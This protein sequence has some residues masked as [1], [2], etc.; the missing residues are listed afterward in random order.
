M[1][2][3]QQQQQSQQPQQ[4]APPQQPQ[5][6]QAA[7]STQQ[8]SQ[9][10]QQQHPV[11]PATP[12]PTPPTQH[13]L[14]P[15]QH[16]HQQHQQQQNSAVSSLASSIAMNTMAIT[17]PNNIGIAQQG[18]VASI[19]SPLPQVQV[20]HQAMHSPSYLPQ[21]SYNQQQ[22]MLQNA[23]M[24]AAMQ[25]S[26][27][28]IN[29]Q[30]LN[31][32]NMAV[33]MQGRPNS[34]MTA[35]QG[36]L[37]HS[38]TQVQQ[39]NGR[40]RL[41]LDSWKFYSDSRAS[42]P[43][44][45]FCFLDHFQ[46]GTP[47]I[48]SPP[49]SQAY[50]V[51]ATNA[52]S[53]TGAIMGNGNKM[54]SQAV[55]QQHMQQAQQVA[56]ATAMVGK[57]V[58]SNQ[59]NPPPLLIGQLGV[60]PG[61]L[62][63]N[64][65]FGP[66]SKQ[67]QSLSMAGQAQPQLISTQAPVRFSQAQLV[68][69]TGQIITSQPMLTN[70]IMQAMAANLQQGI[71]IAHQPI[72]SAPNQSP[73]I[74]TG[75][76]IYLRP[77]SAMQQ[78]GIMGVQAAAINPNMRGNA[79]QSL[80][81]RPSSAAIP[82]QK[83]TTAAQTGKVILPSTSKSATA[84]IQPSIN[85]NASGTKANI[86]SLKSPKALGRPKGTGKATSA[87][88]MSGSNG[89]PATVQAKTSAQISKPSTP[90]SQVAQSLTTH[91]SKSQSDSELEVG[92]KIAGGNVTVPLAV[93]PAKEKREE[94]EDSKE[95][96]SKIGA[97]S[98]LEKPR[99]I[100]TFELKCGQDSPM[101]VAEKQRA[102]VK[103]HILTHVIDGFIIQEGP[104]P[105][106]VQRSSL[107]TEFIPPKPGQPIEQVPT[108]LQNNDDVFPTA[109]P[110]VCTDFSEGI[111]RGVKKRRNMF[112]RRGWR[113]RGGRMSGPGRR[114]PSHLE[115]EPMEE[116]SSSQSSQESSSTADSPIHTPVLEMEV[117]RSAVPKTNPARWN[118]M[119]V[120]EFIQSLPGCAPY[121]EEFRSQEIDGQALLLL[122][123]DHLMTAMNMKLGPALKICARINSLKDECS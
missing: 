96:I 98:L 90:T 1:M 123:E 66:H 23:A 28:N 83:Q 14:A 36:M 65:T 56:Q 93:K 85:A 37:T 11:T 101:P 10:Q 53:K 33:A 26:G 111:T 64:Q 107:M 112:K 119:E 63:T 57:T 59:S 34:N 25:A 38:P 82:I 51:Q 105:F 46:P 42:L 122:K 17:M 79:P 102:I 22:L 106:P 109:S 97:V 116:Q 41:I 74:I 55:T 21:F 120:Y 18:A 110:N 54:S 48:S 71:P 72:L 117:D 49:T 45:D 58:M 52:N 86:P 121:A 113:G 3:D 92:K 68:S 30:Q 75:Q 24:Q 9:Q 7:A 73:T 89:S 50:N 39:L 61:H 12:Q 15:Q 99:E 60:L 19:R 108:S 103:P 100:P 91:T 76:G 104:E 35:T 5:Q 87:A 77:A 6:Q 13:Q 31:L 67:G 84:K 114:T 95:N 62:A 29:P 27:M 4:Q 32:A 88:S 47:M 70:Q 2:A 78:Q 8:P 115:D 80:Q 69:S 20:I 44:R 118:V 43:S 40:N 94:E 81:V 16:Q